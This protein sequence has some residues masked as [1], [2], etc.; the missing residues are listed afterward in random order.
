MYVYEFKNM[1]H[2]GILCTNLYNYFSLKYWKMS[3]KWNRSIFSALNERGE[4]HKCNQVQL[5]F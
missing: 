5:Y 2:Y 4:G 1:A 3:L